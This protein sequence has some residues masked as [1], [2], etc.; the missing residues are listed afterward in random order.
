[1]NQ[2]RA[3][4]FTTLLLFLPLACKDKTE[5]EGKQPTAA[6]EGEK[7]LA[8]AAA[9]AVAPPTSG[10]EGPP[11]CTVK[12]KG[13]VNG[14]WIM[15][16]KKGKPGIGARVGAFADSTYWSTAEDLEI[17]R[18]NDIDK[19]LNLRCLW[20]KGT[21]DGAIELTSQASTRNEV[22]QGPGKYPLVGARRAKDAIKPGQ[23][24]VVALLMNKNM[25]SVTSG[26][27]EIA[28]FDGRGVAGSFKVSAKPM[29]VQNPT[30]AG[31]IELEATFDIP[32][33]GTGS[34]TQ[35]A[36]KQ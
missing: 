32:C 29:V 33:G 16:W 3:P 15:F 14:E 6:A 10:G 9:A 27:L 36:C 25:Y 11:A 35:H 7:P 18:K 21:D 4:I 23:F 20:E 34:S 19:V 8:E 30:S 1:M 24:T 5:A 13:H 22:P 26:A 17:A 2:R 12:V 28:R 31:T